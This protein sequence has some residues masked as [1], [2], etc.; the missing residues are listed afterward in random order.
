[1]Y[2]SFHSWYVV[3]PPG[4][5]SSISLGNGSASPPPPKPALL[6]TS[7][8]LPR[9]CPPTA[10]SKP[11]YWLTQP[12]HPITGDLNAYE[13]SLSWPFSCFILNL[14]Q[15]FFWP[16]R[17]L[18]SVY[19]PTK[20]TKRLESFTARPKLLPRSSPRRA[21][22]RTRV[23]PKSRVNHKTTASISRSPTTLLHRPV[24]VQQTALPQ[25]QLTHHLDKACLQQATPLA[26]PLRRST[27]S[28][29]LTLRQ[30]KCHSELGC[31]C[32]W[33]LVVF[34]LAA[35]SLAWLKL[36]DKNLVSVSFNVSEK[37]AEQNWI[38]L[39]WTEQKIN[40]SYH[41]SLIQS[42]I[43][44]T[45]STNPD[46]RSA[47]FPLGGFRKL[48]CVCWCSQSAVHSGMH[49]LHSFSGWYGALIP[50]SFK[51]RPQ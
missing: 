42:E 50:I 1:M 40:F 45:L 47:V 8:N 10:C 32:V 25:Q 31:V 12:V 27:G 51:F 15:L 2:F 20:S 37:G 39:F 28:W 46:W 30:L 34:F 35:G 14:M 44:R 49:V 21:R 23:H 22:A 6:R 13:R 16:F 11:S 17:W 41:L 33:E 19:Q 36:P 48:R 38:V 43:T 26:P 29:L 3:A 9:C 24:P 4:L 7:R 5:P 18:R